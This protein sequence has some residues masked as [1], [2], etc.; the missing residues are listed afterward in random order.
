MA[1]SNTKPAAQIA[2]KF[3]TPI[4]VTAASAAASY[5]A[6]KA[7]AYLEET[8]LPKL[9]D[10]TSGASGI[11]ETVPQRAKA[12]AGS[13]GDLAEDLTD[14]ARGV[15]GGGDDGRSRGSRNGKRLTTE[16]LERRHARRA[17]ARAKRRSGSS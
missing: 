6:K 8:V 1:E 17:E 13:V 5:V 9:R 4:V 3:L 15:V 16:E 2:K 11:A 14:R 7:P 12:A 10:A